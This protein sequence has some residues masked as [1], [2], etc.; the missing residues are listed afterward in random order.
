MSSEEK[1]PLNKATTDHLVSSPWW[2]KMGWMAIIWLGSVL[3]L[4]AF[5]SLFKLLMTAAGMKVK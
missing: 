5:S 4:F 2:K 1:L 3:A